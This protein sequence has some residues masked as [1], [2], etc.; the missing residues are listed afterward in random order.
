[1][2]TE[3]LARRVLEVLDAQKKFFRS[4]STA[5]LEASKALE[6]A[7]RRDCEEILDPQPTFFR[8]DDDR[9]APK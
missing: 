4:R 6:R 7:L 5:D 1:M 8:Q 3:E 2:T 9:W